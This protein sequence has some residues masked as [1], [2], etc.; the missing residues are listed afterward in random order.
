M[1]L[2]F[3]SKKTGASKVIVLIIV[4]LILQAG[5]SPQVSIMGGGINFMFV[6]VC[7]MA[8]LSSPSQT[9]VAGFLGGL[10]YDF[11]SATPI[12]AMALLLTIGAF[13]LSR[14]MAQN[15]S[16]SSS[17]AATIFACSLFINVVFAIML[18]SMGVQTD[19]VFALFGHAL[20]CSVLDALL[21]VPA[22]HFFANSD[23]SINFGSKSSASHFKT[24]GLK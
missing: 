14:F 22:L 12:G 16:S 23:S 13:L 9:V 1:A 7:G 18:F 8:L 24:S 2:D 17:R 19:L 4:C 20:P 5:L 10:F 15:A 11:T 6:M 3:S 21:S